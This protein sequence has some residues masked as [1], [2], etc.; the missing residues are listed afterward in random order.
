MAH[1]GDDVRLAQMLLEV[2]IDLE[3]EAEAIE[4]EQTGSKPLPIDPLEPAPPWL[5]GVQR[6]A[7]ELNPAVPASAGESV[8]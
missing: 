6:P 8:T 3:A 1:G 5:R 7:R 2:A 4:A